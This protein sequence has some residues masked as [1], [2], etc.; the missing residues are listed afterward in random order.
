MGSPERLLQARL[1]PMF[2]SIRSERMLRNHAMFSKNHERRLSEAV[3]GEL[4]DGVP[5]QAQRHLSQGRSTVAGTMIEAW[6]PGPSNE[7]FK[8]FAPDEE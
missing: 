6:P 8:R 3:S 4:F 1:L 5:K 2:Y 7:R